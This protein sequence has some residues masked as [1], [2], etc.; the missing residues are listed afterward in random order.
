MSFANVAWAERVCCKP[1]RNTNLEADP[2]RCS[3][4]PS[5]KQVPIL[6]SPDRQSTDLELALHNAKLASY[7]HVA[8]PVLA[9]RILACKVEGTTCLCLKLCAFCRV[10][11][12]R[13]LLSNRHEELVRLPSSHHLTMTVPNTP[14]LKRAALD[15]VR[16]SFK[17]LR[18][19]KM[20]SSAVRGG[21]VNLAAD[22]SGDDWHIHVHALL[23]CQSSLDERKLSEEW[24]ALTGGQKVKLQ[25]VYRRTA[26]VVFNYGTKLDNLPLNGR[27][28]GE[29]LDAVHGVRLV[30][31]WGTLYR[32]PAPM[33]SIT[34]S[35]DA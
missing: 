1:M 8:R 10:R 21:L 25:R 3:D 4:V 22:W 9:R 19:S 7:L 18:R 16:K 35:E 31:G 12:G 2:S 32:V 29:Y 13:R 24:R 15:H 30:T 20:F 6:Y 26:S 34:I 17:A 28:L 5:N 27:L 14:I 33:T 11:R 23:D